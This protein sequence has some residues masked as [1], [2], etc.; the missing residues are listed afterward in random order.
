M[1]QRAEHR[2]GGRPA[3]AAERRLAASA[4]PA[5]SACRGPP[6][7]PL[8]AVI[9][10]RISS[11]RL[12]PSRQGVHLPHDSSCGERHEELGDVDHAVVFVQHDHAAAAH[13]RAGLGQGVVVD[14]QIDALGRDAAAGRPAGLDGLELLAAAARRRR[15]RRRPRAAWC[16]WAL[17]PARCAAPCRP[18]RR[19]WCRRC[20]AV[21]MRLNQSAPNLMTAGTLAKV[22]TLLI[23]VGLPHR[24]LSVG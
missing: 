6:A 24:P 5:A 11:I 15:S 14:P 23:T 7:S 16:P 8:P 17:R 22:S 9:R 13:D 18:G 4:A 10:S 3:Q 2:I 20:A 19:P 21:P 1:L 12:V